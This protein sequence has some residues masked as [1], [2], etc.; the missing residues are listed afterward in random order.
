MRKTGGNAT[1]SLAEGPRASGWRCRD[2]SAL[3]IGICRSRW[4]IYWARSRVDTILGP[5][6]RAVFSP[7]SKLHADRVLRSVL[8]AP[9]KMLLQT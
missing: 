2:V 4:L 6:M 5:P 1:V 9:M 7:K 3:P 8:G